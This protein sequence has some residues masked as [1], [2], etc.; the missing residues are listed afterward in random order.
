MRLLTLIVIGACVCLALPHP[1]HAGIAG[2]TPNM[3]VYRSAGFRCAALAEDNSKILSSARKQGVKLAA[4][5]AGDVVLPARTACGQLT[6]RLHCRGTYGDSYFLPLRRGRQ[7]FDVYKYYGSVTATRHL[8]C[9]LTARCQH[10]HAAGKP[11]TT[12]PG[13]DQQG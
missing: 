12:Y 5:L 2:T 7:P 1:G 10:R 11:G 13:G 4:S 3:T 9:R 8:G 6:R